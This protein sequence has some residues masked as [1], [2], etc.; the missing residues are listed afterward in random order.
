MAEE[1]KRDPLLPVVVV[2]GVAV[3]AVVVVVLVGAGVGVGVGGAVVVVVLVGAG[4]GGAVVVGH[5]G[6]SS[7]RVICSLYL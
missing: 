1:E 2:G 7:F 3:V 5:E 6:K 4:V